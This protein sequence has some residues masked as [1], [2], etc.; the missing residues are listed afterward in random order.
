MKKGIIIR[1][2]IN[3]FTF[4]GSTK[5]PMQKAVRDALI[6]FMAEMAQ[7]Q[8]EGTKDAQRAGIAHAKAADPTAYR[9]RKPSFT[10][11]QFSTVL[12]LASQGAMNTSQIA[13]S[14][15]LERMAVTRIR[16]D[17][18]KSERQLVTWGM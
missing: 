9:G 8:A 10:R 13:K 12:T 7:A 4:D 1:T 14:V 15:G 6:G 17:P 11:E 18:A 5:D 3:G 16:Q 2:V